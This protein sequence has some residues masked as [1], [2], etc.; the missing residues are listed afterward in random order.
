MLLSD[1]YS[2]LIDIIMGF[3]ISFMV[4]ENFGEYVSHFCPR[5]SFFLFFEAK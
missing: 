1:K 4:C 5:V 2:L 3:L